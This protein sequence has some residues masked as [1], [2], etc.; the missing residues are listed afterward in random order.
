MSGEDRLDSR[1]RANRHEVILNPKHR[2][3]PSTTQRANS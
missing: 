3:L 2:Q 1:D